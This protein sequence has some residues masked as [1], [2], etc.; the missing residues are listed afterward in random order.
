L[1]GRD[2]GECEP[3]LPDEAGQE[4][5]RTSKSKK[6]IRCCGPVNARN[7]I[8]I[9]KMHDAGNGVLQVSG[10]AEYFHSLD[11]ARC[12]LVRRIGTTVNS[13][14]LNSDNSPRRQ[15][16]S[17]LAYD[18]K[19]HRCL[20]NAALKRLATAI[21]GATKPPMALA[22]PHLTSIGKRARTAPP[23]G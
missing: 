21:K 17:Q 23:S 8:V 10:G 2:A 11:A 18:S 20:N 1:E 7:S 3:D 5:E 15:L 19:S 4:F 13:F 6:F 16:I 14:A 22:P 9:A 12:L